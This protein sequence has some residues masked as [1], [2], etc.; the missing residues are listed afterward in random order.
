MQLLAPSHSQFADQDYVLVLPRDCF[1]TGSPAV[2]SWACTAPS[3]E[4][5]LMRS[6]LKDQVQ[7]SLVIAVI[8]ISCSDK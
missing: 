5:I 7:A 6:E 3:L 2:K 8:A 1:T 4:V